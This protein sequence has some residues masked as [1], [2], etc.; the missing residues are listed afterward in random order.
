[1]KR[2]LL[3]LAV[4]FSAIAIEA[5]TLVVYYSYTNNVHEIV[6]DLTKQ[7][8]AD[9]VRIEPVEKGLY[10]EA[11]GYAI[12][13]AQISEIRNNPDDAASYPVIDPVDVN[14]KDYDCIIIGA[15]LW[16]SN[17]AAPLQ[18]YLFQN[19]PMQVRSCHMPSLV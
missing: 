17:M 12:G 10:Y 16:W 6:T 18:T 2:L 11:D 1:M 15:P 13:S 5:K 14:L 9:V 19:G 7:I 3:S 8:D 4:T